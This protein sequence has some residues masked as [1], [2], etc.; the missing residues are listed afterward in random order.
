MILHKIFATLGLIVVMTTAGAQD[1]PRDAGL[2]LAVQAG[3]ALVE[4]EGFDE[5]AGTFEATVDLRLRWRDGR[6]AR[7][8]GNMLAPP[9]TL[10]DEA[11]EERLAQIWVP[12]VVLANQIGDPSKDQKGLRIFADGTVEM[13]RRITSMFKADVN[14]DR[15][16]FDRQKL[17]IEAVVDDRSINEVT[18]KAAQSDLDFSR[19]A[20]D[21][22]LSGWRVGLID[23]TMPP[24]AGWYNTNAAR[25]IATVDI[26]REPGLAVASMLIP[27]VA[28]LLIPLLALW[29]N[30]LEEGVFQ[31]DTFEL[32]NI[33]IGGFF[34]VIALNFTVLSSYPA[35][36]DGNNAV[37]RLLTLNYGTLAIALVISI[38]FG[39]FGVLASSFGVFVQEQTY[40]LL[41][42][43]L[44]V[45]LAAIVLAIMGVAY[46]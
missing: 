33:V 36:A 42:W 1:I 12:D 34:A 46:V 17:T 10:R 15:F 18:L 45:S 23:L 7:T 24:S 30:H 27:L 4:L 39:R 38:L 41:M 22:T 26:T 6:L 32:V 29:L 2:P 5:N 14:M 40:K 21:V 3:V 9:L 35:L 8:D 20:R 43:A 28:S 25:L 11:A 19:V 16:P 13:L 44:P 31:V 37:M